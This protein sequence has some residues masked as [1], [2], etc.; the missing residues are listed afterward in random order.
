MKGLAAVTIIAD[1]VIFAPAVGLGKEEQIL[2]CLSVKRKQVEIKLLHN[3]TPLALVVG[4]RRLEHFSRLR[5]YQSFLFH[6]L[7]FSLRSQGERLIY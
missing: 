5:C 4:K 3:N 7:P 2:N 6:N 1:H